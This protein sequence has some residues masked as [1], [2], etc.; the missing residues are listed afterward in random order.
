MVNYSMI[1]V[2]AVFGAL[3]V[4]A[5][6]NQA[7]ADP[8]LSDPAFAKARDDAAAAANCTNRVN[9]IATSTPKAR[10]PDA[11]K[12]SR[13]SGMALTESIV[14]T[15]GRVAF[16][17]VMRADDPAFGKAAVEALNK[18]RYKPATCDGQPVPTFV[19]IT[20]TFSAQ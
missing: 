4:A 8:R 17:R 1:L 3:H 11:L 14:L 13:K 20:H 5:A 6:A 9:P 18:Y 12:P 15:N 7:S 16:T 10:Y 2:L 19:T